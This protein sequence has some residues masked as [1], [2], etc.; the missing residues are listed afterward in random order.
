MPS[1]AGKQFGRNELGAAYGL[2]IQPAYV[3]F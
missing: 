1:R 2:Y 3:R